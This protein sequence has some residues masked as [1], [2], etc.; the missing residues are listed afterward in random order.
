MKKHRKS[1]FG[2][3]FAVVFLV[4]AIVSGVSLE[5]KIKEFN[6]D[7]GMKVLIFVARPSSR[8]EVLRSKK[9]P[10]IVYFNELIVERL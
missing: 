7:N 2:F 1:L 4:P 5:G 3:I 6:L 10:S 8:A 9:F